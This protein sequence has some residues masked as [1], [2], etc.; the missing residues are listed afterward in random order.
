VGCQT[1]DRVVRDIT[2]KQIGHIIRWLLELIVI[3]LFVLPE[4]GVWT[5]I[6]LTMI[7]VGIEGNFFN[8]ES[9]K[10]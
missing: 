7:T 8:I 9:R 1:R 3:W 10:Q 5:A 6:S 2:L 4:T